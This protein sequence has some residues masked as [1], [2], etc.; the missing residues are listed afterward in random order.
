MSY[1]SVQ[2]VAGM[3]PTF[4]RGT[5]QQKPADTLIQQYVDD[6]AGDIDAALERRFGLAIQQTYAS[7]FA[8]F[9][10]ALNLAS[11]QWQPSTAYAL[12]ALAL[13]ANGN[14]Q[15]CTV[16]GTSGAA[17]PA[18]SVI[19]GASTADNTATWQ[20]VAS[21]A[22]RILEKINRYGAAAQLGETLATFGIASAA[23]LAKSFEA[24]FEEKLSDLMAVD[25]RGNSMS[26]GLY[27]LLFDPLSA[28]DNPRPELQGIAGGE[29]P[30][31]QTAADL[32]N[33]NFFSKFQKL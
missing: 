26:S 27:D 22:S 21:D 13:D 33:S 17:A 23:L 20:N 19:P 8:A 32:G 4:A 11:L 10:A 1:T 30:V 14:P 29:M 25:E 2:S 28:V 9:Q 18:W 6:V 24:E 5:P 16:A 31:G 15:K 7:S 12:N 3:F